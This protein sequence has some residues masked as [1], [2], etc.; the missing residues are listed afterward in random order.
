MPL[1][2]VLCRPPSCTSAVLEQSPAFQDVFATTFFLVSLIPYLMTD[3]KHLKS[4]VP[5]KLV[6]PT[7]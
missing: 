2:R 3:Y 5:L 7:T 6:I 4:V 1:C